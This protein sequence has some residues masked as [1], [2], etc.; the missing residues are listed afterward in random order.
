[1][2]LDQLLV[3]RGLFDS[4]EQARRAVRRGA[5]R[6][7]GEEASKPALAVTPDAE[8]ELADEGRRFVSRAG[9][10]LAAALDAFAIDPSGWVCLDVGA[11]TGGFTDCLLARGA[12]R[13]HALDVG[14]DQLDPRLRRDPR[15]VCHEGVNARHLPPDFLPEPCDLVTF[16]LS[17]ISV[18][19]VVPAVLPSLAA[20]GLAILLLKPQ[21]EVGPAGVGKGGVVR[22]ERLRRSVLERR[23]REL[24]ELGLELLGMMD[25]PLPGRAGNRE[26][27]ACYRRLPGGDR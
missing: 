19:K 1:M 8:V 9:R 16:D 5:V 14:R 17:F 23:A 24:T 4:R 21:F 7:E 12:A 18:L 6:V 13:V 27:L 25:S 2:R 15:V 3:Q 11:S 20:G 10:K 26:A 22:D